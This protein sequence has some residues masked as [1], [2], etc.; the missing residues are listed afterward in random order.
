MIRI[1]RR[2]MKVGDILISKA[3]GAISNFS[4]KVISID[5]EKETCNLKNLDSGES[6][7]DYSMSDLYKLIDQN[8]LWFYKEHE[9]SPVQMT[10]RYRTIGD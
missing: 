9:Y 7:F 10:G 1:S 6:Y 4:Y 8:D 2:D 3:Y 5:L